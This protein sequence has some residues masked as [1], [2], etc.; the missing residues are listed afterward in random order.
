LAA[1]N[2]S[3]FEKNIARVRS[4]LEKEWIDKSAGGYAFKSPGLQPIR[5]PPALLCD[6]AI[7]IVRDTFY[8]WSLKLTE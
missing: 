1:I 3:D 6:W 4:M 2:W 8:P 5:L 7:A